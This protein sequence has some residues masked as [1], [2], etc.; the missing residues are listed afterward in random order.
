VGVSIRKILAATSSMNPVIRPV[1]T[2]AM[3]HLM[4][5]VGHLLIGSGWRW[6]H[7]GPISV[8]AYPVAASTD[9]LMMVPPKKPHIKISKAM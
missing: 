7:R 6:R 2:A 3:T 9:E 4:T 1:R 8:G 5:S